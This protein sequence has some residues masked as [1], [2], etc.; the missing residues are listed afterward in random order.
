MSPTV[1]EG[2]YRM[3]QRARLLWKSLAIFFC[4]CAVSGVVAWGILLTSLCTNPRAPVPE[5]Q[6]VI[7]YN[8]HGMTTF[9]TPLAEMLKN[10]LI[11]A[12]IVFS[13]LGFLVAGAMV[14]LSMARIRIK[15]EAGIVDT[16][17]NSAMREGKS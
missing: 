13:L 14:L 12:L 4:A 5:T 6:H 11:P 1:E 7:A 8:C 3:S 17:G 10:W 2:Q 16:S 9:M 15:V